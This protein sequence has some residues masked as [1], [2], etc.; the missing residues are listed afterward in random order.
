MAKLIKCKAAIARGINMPLEVMEI[1]VDPPHAGEVRIKLVS[2]SICATDSNIL[3]GKALDSV[4]YQFPCILGHEGAGIIES[5]G[6]GVKDLNIGD[7]VVLVPV[8]QC[9]KCYFC[10]NDKTNICFTR[11]HDSVVMVDG[12]TRFHD[13]K[14]GEPL[15]HFLGLSTWSQ[16]TVVSETQ[17]T[18]IDDTVP[19]E[20]VCL[21]SCG[22]LTGYGAPLNGLKLER[23]T[24][25]GIWGLGTVGLAAALA[26]KALGAKKIIGIDLNEQKFELA[27]NFGVDEFIN[28]KS[29]TDR[30]VDSLIKEK[31]R[32][33]LDYA[34][35]CVGS[36]Q[37]MRAALDS[38]R[39][40]FGVTLLVGASPSGDR[41]SVLPLEIL[42]GKTLKGVFLGGFKP[43][44]GVK[45]L[46][47]QYLKVTI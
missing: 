42:S 17:V 15:Y 22:I 37:T 33:G 47:D 41:L 4:K 31:T 8:P 27:R 40:G 25:V 12:K 38:T 24:T 13:G 34:I 26:A 7:H 18:K 10:M 19:L 20:K 21:L 6:D 23:G 2:A 43:K 46:V 1:H 44:D 30:S 3:A 16:Y 5:V 28:P 45:Y 35:E 32:F 9:R 36:I 11:T 14:T 29:L 39:L